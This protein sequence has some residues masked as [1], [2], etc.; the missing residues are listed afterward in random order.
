MGEAESERRGELG[1]EFWSSDFRAG[2][3]DGEDRGAF[4][5]LP[6]FVD[7]IINV[8]GGNLRQA[9]LRAGADQSAVASGRDVLFGGQGQTQSGIADKHRGVGG[10]EHLRNVGSGFAQ[11]TRDDPPGLALNFSYVLGAP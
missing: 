8:N 2:G 6:P 11:L 4:R 5:K 1:G 7:H 10:G 9:D 3:P